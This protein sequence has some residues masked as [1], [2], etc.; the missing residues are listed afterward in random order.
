MDKLL[1]VVV[2]IYK[3]EKYINKCL[4]SLVLSENQMKLLEGICVNDGTQDNSAIM[5]K[6]YEKRYPDTFIVIDKEN[7]GHGSA[8]NKG[9]ELATGKYLRF[10]DSDDWLTNLSSFLEELQNYDV[11]IIITDLLRVNEKTGNESLTSYSSSI[12]PCTI[13]LIN[14]FDWKK[15][16]NINLYGSNITNFHSSTYKT[17]LIKKHHPVFLERI[18]YDDE[19]LHV[20]PYCCA[21]TFVYLNMPLYNYLIG[22]DG[23][24]IDPKVRAK[25]VGFKVK[26][27]QYQV[28][29]YK[30]HLPQV[31]MINKRVQRILN[32]RISVTFR[33]MA[34]LPRKE[35]I[36]QM[37]EFY[38]WLKVHYPEFKGNRGF[39][40]YKVSP[41]LYRL[42]SNHG[43]ESMKSVYD[44][45]P[46]KIKLKTHKIVE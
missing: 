44:L 24:T 7:G 10:L 42:V 23:Q 4:D 6:E 41:I 34:K 19:I 3:V 21:K 30:E 38:S 33:W 5:A 27:H 17:E 29:F 46:A 28:R 12:T 43:L 45:L 25:N 14:E 40:L 32:E 2:P 22:R 16:D 36:F 26:V 35:S 8:W 31:E 15:V 1:T 37:N 9:V 18:F 20:L 11:D 39:S 13:N